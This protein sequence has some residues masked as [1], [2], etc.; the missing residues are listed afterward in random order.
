M[1]DIADFCAEAGKT[2]GDLSGAAIESHEKVQDGLYRTGYSGG[3]LVYVNYNN[4]SVNVNSITIPPY[5]YI[6]IN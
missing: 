6:R 5:S 2:L 4:Y 3:T 1:S